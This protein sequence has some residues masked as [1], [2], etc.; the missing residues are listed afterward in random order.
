[1]KCFFLVIIIFALSSNACGYEYD[2]ALDR[3]AEEMTTCSAYFTVVYQVLKRS[4]DKNDAERAEKF[5]G[6]MNEAVKY[7][8]LMSS[9]KI[10][11]ARAE[12]KIKEMLR[13]TDNNPAA[14]MSVLYNKYGF[15]CMDVM[16]NP[17]KRLKQWLDM[18]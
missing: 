9:E 2:L 17:F 16:E 12:T 11:L 10:M 1:M 5:H 15:W 4:T 8:I 6:Q 18:K 14:N 7:S 3:Q 13:E